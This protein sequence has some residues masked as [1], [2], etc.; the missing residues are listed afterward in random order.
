MLHLR[1]KKG[2]KVWNVMK[3]H[4]C[5]RLP[6][7]V[8]VVVGELVDDDVKSLSRVQNLWSQVSK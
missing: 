1:S 8:I 7:E 3:R 5:L 6:A 4:R 2:K